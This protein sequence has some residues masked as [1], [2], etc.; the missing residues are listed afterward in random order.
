MP[1]FAIIVRLGFF[2]MDLIWRVCLVKIFRLF[3][4]G[5]G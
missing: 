3:F 1:D 5:G 4:L 2:F